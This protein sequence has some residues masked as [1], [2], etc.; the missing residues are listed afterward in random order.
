MTVR[1]AVS[2][3]IDFSKARL[4]DVAWWR[5]ANILIQAMDYERELEI[6]K[7]AYAFQCSLVANGSLT[8]DS[9]KSVQKGAKV[10][11][12]EIIN[13]M[14]PW[15][16]QTL[17]EIQQKEMVGLTELYKRVIGDIDDPN[18]RE[19]L[20]HDIEL[21]KEARKKARAQIPEEEM[22]ARRIAQA[23][24]ERRNRQQKRRWR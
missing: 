18:F 6:I 5:R 21:D 3:V 15:A 10:T 14:Q 19:K 24:A 17:E 23:A 20:E 11:F 7:A 22:I 4:L 16:A 12:N 8:E 9:F 13:A 1:A 2:G